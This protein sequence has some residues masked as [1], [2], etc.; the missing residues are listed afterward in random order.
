MLYTEAGAAKSNI[1]FPSGTKIAAW[2]KIEKLSIDNKMP[3]CTNGNITPGCSETIGDME[4]ASA[5]DD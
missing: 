2:C 4:I 1:K 3:P 5:S